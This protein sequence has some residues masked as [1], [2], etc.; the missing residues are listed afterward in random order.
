MSPA[1]RV[2]SWAKGAWPGLL[3]AF[4]L[5]LL[6]R[7][8]PGV[9]HDGRL[10]VAAALA[11]LDPSGVGQDL[12]FVHDGQFGFSLY[13]PMLAQLIRLLGISG[14]TM[15]IVALTLVLWFAAAALMVER[16]LADRPAGL[17]WAALVFVATLPSLYG[18]LN[19]IGF[20]EPYATPRGL[21]EAAGLAGMAAYLSGRR[22]LG[23]GACAFGMLF[24]PIMGLCSAAAIALALCLEDRRWLWAGLAGVGAIILAGLAHLPVADRIVTVMDPAW[25]AVVETRSPI[26]FTSLWPIEAWS[27]LAVQACTLAA[28]AFLLEGRARRLALGALVAGLLGVAVVAV[29]G[30]RLSLLLFLQVQSWRTLQPL[31]VLA[32]ACLAPLC[33]ELPRRGPS[34][35]IALALLGLGWMFRDLGAAGLLTAPVGLLFVMAGGAMRFSHPRLFSGLAVGLLAVAAGLCVQLYVAGL[36]HKL[37]RI[38][39]YSQTIVWFSDLPGLLIASVL[40]VWLARAWSPPPVAIR[41]A[42]AAVI[43]LLAA[44]LWD[45]RSAFVRFRDRGPDPA[46]VALTAARPGPVL[47]LGG[48]VEPW[49]LMSRASWSAKVQGAGVVFSRPLALEIRNRARRLTE[50]GLVGEDFERPL[51]VPARRPPSPDRKRVE[52]F[53]AASDAPAWIIW[54]RWTDA[55]PPAS[56]LAAHEWTPGA[57]FV[58]D[59]LESDAKR[60][61]RA[62]RYAVIPCAGE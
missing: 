54:P 23:L 62:D 22:F 7:A 56:A 25:R 46:L 14:G 17:R 50:A 8:Y 60:A 45:D 38:D 3:A 52:A 32:L 55:P 6:S 49:L 31:A 20:A 4:G 35:L 26:L 11:K 44:A 47:W 33:A 40:G 10:Y 13:T 18:P 48:D 5:F 1:D 61:P 36:V 9:Y 15:A 39:D 21:V 27:R 28:G 58:N 29:L 59:L 16:F 57:P 42:G 2:S 30:D 53:C 12:M 19:V 34:G 24:H 43:V 37:G 41:L 51:T